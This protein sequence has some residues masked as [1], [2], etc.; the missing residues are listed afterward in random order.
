MPLLA[1]VLPAFAADTALEF[2]G[3][4]DYVSLG[5]LNPGTSFTLESWV[6]VDSYPSPTY[7]TLWEVHAP[8]TALNALYVGY[9]GGSWSIAVED[10]NVN[11]G[12]NCTSDTTDGLCHATAAATGTPYHLAVVVTPT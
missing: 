2:D 4:G 5:V 12:A 9:V 10:A 11:E 1:L 6:E 3:D 7:T 8:A